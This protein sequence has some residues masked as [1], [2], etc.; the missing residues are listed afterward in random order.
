M[1]WGK[2][3]GYW[4]SV[5]LFWIVFVLDFMLFARLLLIHNLYQSI[6]EKISKFKNT[7]I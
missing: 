5:C 4:G 7:E 1:N 6:S 2:G 3:I